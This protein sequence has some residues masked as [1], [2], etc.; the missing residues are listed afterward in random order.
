MKENLTV[1]ICFSAKDRY[2]IAEPIVHHLKNYGIDIWYDRYAMVL[3]DNRI[4][5]NLKEV[6][7][8]GTLMDNTSR[9]AFQGRNLMLGTEEFKLLA[10]K[11]M[12]MIF[13]IAFSF[14]KS[15][16]DAEDVTQDVLLR[17]YETDYVFESQSHIK[18]W[19]AKVTCNECR[20]FWR[21][22][23]HKQENI[24]DYADRLAF[25]EKSYQDLFTAV[26]RLDKAKR[27]VVILYYLEG[28]QIHEIAEL[29][30]IPQ[31]TVGTRLARARKELR[32]Y[33][34]DEVS[35]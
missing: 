28:Y 25:E 20:K 22:L 12:D 4:E 15:Q 11:H 27:I 26:M 8:N 30:E 6:K 31:G 34:E 5:K 9:K 32:K 23:P 16:S 33:L 29:L 13:R 35:I 7:K 3:G 21:R 24:S 14:L 17:L 19:L 2:T 10:E 1:F 18:N